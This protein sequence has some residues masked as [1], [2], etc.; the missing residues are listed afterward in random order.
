VKI[1][2]KKK[3]FGEWFA[4]EMEEILSKEETTEIMFRLLE[5]EGVNRVDYAIAKEL[6]L[7]SLRW[8]NFVKD[9]KN[10]KPVQYILGYEYFAGDK[11]MVDENV[12]IP[13]PETE[14]L[15]NWIATEQKEAEKLKILEVGTGSGCIS[16]SLKKKLPQADILATDISEGALAVANKNSTA[17]NVAVNFMLDDILNTNLGSQN[18]DVIVSNPPYIPIE[19]FKT[20]DERVRSHEPN[21]ALF[22]EEEKPLQFYKAILEVASN[23]LNANGVLYFEIHEDYA[24]AVCE[25]AKGKSWQATIK[26]DF[27]GKERMVKINSANFKAVPN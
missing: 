26:K 17:L 15:V 4:H 24:K 1:S 18:F 7:D 5:H 27:Y 25:L 14:E 10:H 23:N 2:F 6:E 16:I 11:F 8:M 3:E 9:L 13:R 12:L 21:L 22:T 20:L 19:D